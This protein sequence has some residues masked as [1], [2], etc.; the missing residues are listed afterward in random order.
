MCK[1][2][3][4]C[5]LLNYRYLLVVFTQADRLVSDEYRVESIIVNIPDVPRELELV[6]SYEYSI[7]AKWQ[8]VEQAAVSL[9]KN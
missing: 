1:I 4:L 2:L 7:T 8:R 9:N 6:N 3:Q 5:L